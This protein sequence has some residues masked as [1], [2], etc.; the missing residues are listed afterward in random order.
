[1]RVNFADLPRLN[2]QV[3]AGSYQGPFEGWRHLVTLEEIGDH[4]SE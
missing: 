1:M 4:C 3:D 2:I